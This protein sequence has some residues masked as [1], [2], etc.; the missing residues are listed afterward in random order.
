VHDRFSGSV[1]I[2]LLKDLNGNTDWIFANKTLLAVAGGA[3]FRNINTIADRAF[4]GEG[5]GK[6]LNCR[7][8]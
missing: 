5:S 8:G 2:C 3:M 7:V 4:Y 1:Q 6:F